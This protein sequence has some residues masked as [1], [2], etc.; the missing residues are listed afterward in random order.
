MNTGKNRS[1]F[2]LIE[3]LVVVAII[4]MLISLVMPSLSRVRE[5]ARSAGCRSHLRQLGV[6]YMLYVGDH[7]GQLTGADA[8]SSRGRFT[9]NRNLRWDNWVLRLAP[10]AG[11]EVTTTSWT[12][13]DI[14]WTEYPRGSVFECPSF[15]TQTRQ[16]A[17]R[18]GPAGLWTPY[19]PYGMPWFGIGGR[20]WGSWPGVYLIGQISDP[21]TLALLTDSRGEEDGYVHGR[22]IVG[23]EHSPPGMMHFRHGGDRDANVLFVTGHVITGGRDVW[24]EPYD[25][26]PRSGPWRMRDF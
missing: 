26:V 5:T 10:Y 6:A 24:A 11:T 3:L 20:N 8:R 21:G 13:Q 18:S 17:G 9:D 4:G 1:G 16:D 15:R 7:E 14:R 22:Y 23:N 12:T 2:T 19:V 25:P